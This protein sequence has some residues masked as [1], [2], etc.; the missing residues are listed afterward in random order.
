MSDD[1]PPRWVFREGD[2]ALLVDR[3]GRRHLVTL[4]AGKS[5]HTHAGVLPHDALIG[6]QSGCRVMAGSQKMLAL[7]PTL[8]EYVQEIPRA[9]QIIYPKDVGPILVYGDVFAGARV[10][11]AGLGS[12][13]LTLA[14]LQAVGPQGSVTAYELKQETLEKALRNLRRHGQASAKFS[15]RVANVY[16]AI[17]ERE[18]DRIVL[19]APE[20]WQVVA[21]AAGALVPGGVF[22]SYLPT[23]LQVHRLTEALAAHAEFDLVETFEVLIRPWHVTRRS[24]RPAHRMVAHT[25]FITT[26]RKCAPGKFL[27]PDEWEAGGEDEA[28][29]PS[30]SP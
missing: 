28:E 17:E 13:A 19:D 12:G 10:L 6:R 20:P 27:R 9:T 5:F 11:E 25:G 3:K 21:H 7:K 4:E 30:N 16:E 18:L 15:A 8:A 29:T 1:L 2:L 26:A 23:V 22:L 24:V 14:L